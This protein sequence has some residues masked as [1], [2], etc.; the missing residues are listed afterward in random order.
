MTVSKLLNK[1]NLEQAESGLW[2]LPGAD[3]HNVF[4][5]S[6][7]DDQEAYVMNVIANGPSNKMLS[8]PPCSQEII[9]TAMSF[10]SR[11]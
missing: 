11:K 6:D 1:N 2:Y 5:Y 8:V 3:V 4:A 7:G 9:Q 10:T